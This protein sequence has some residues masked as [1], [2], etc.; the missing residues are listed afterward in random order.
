MNWISWAPTLYNACLTENQPKVYPRE[1]TKQSPSSDWRDSYT[2]EW[3]IRNYRGRRDPSG[4][5]MDCSL[6]AAHKLNLT[7]CQNRKLTLIF[8]GFFL[9]SRISGLGGL[10]WSLIPV[11]WVKDPVVCESSQLWFSEMIFFCLMKLYLYSS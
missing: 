3:L 9:L 1:N 5:Q 2:P 10:I 6:L 11:S 4:K 8:V 7:I